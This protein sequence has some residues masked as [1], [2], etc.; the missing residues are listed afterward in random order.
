MNFDEIRLITSAITDIGYWLI[1]IIG[2]NI[3]NIIDIGGEDM[4]Y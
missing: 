3:S 2:D 4:K 1:K